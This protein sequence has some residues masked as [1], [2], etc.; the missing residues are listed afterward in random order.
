M[1]APFDRV[2]AADRPRTL[3]LLSASA[4]VMLALLNVL[5]SPLKNETS[6]WGVVSLQLSF[7]AENALAMINAWDEDQRL[8]CAFGLGLDYVFMFL[9][10]GAVAAGCVFFGEQLRFRGSALGKW[11]APIAW[12]VVVGGVADMFENSCLL[13]VVRGVTDMAFAASCAA[14]VKFGFLFVGLLYAIPAGI[15]LRLRRT[16]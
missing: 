8:L 10:A 3:A 11:A 7:G 6:P 2:P 5:D 12:L 9:Y 15:F 16:Q 14:V 4:L 13:S 1:R